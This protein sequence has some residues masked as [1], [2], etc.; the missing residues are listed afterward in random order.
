MKL[1]TW[2]ANYCCLYKKA[3]LAQR[4]L[5]QGYIRL[6]RAVSDDTASKNLSKRKWA[7]ERIHTCEQLD[8][9]YLTSEV[10]VGI[11][12][13]VTQSMVF[14]YGLPWTCFQATIR[15]LVRGIPRD[16]GHPTGW[17]WWG[18]YNGEIFEDTGLE[19]QSNVSISQEMVAT[20]RSWKIPW[21]D[22]PFKL[23]RW[24]QPAQTLSQ[25]K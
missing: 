16:T 3:R 13:Q 20:T 19:G 9:E 7:P 25:T 24:Y 5:Y 22:S 23:W 14:Y 4:R 11:L 10:W 12:T 1:L 17:M 15:D 8:H 6:E 2:N 21:P 18:R